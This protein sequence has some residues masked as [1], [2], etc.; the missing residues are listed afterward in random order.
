MSVNR[1][2]RSKSIA[3]TSTVVAAAALAVTS[4]IA[5]GGCESS[6][7]TPTNPV[8]GG[9]SGG[10]PGAKCSPDE[11][12]APMDGVSCAAMPDDYT[13]RE[14]GSSTDTWP[15]CISDKND[16]VP[17]DMNISSLARVAAFEQIREL[18]DIGGTGVPTPQD[19]LDA[20][21]IY[22]QEQGIESRVSRRE[23]EHYPPAPAACRDMPPAEQQMY[24]DRCVGPVKI[25]PILNAAFEGGIAGESPVENAARIEGALLWFFYVSIY[26][27]AT[28]AA[29]NAVDV[30]SM[31][32]KYTGGEPRE[33]GI[34]LSGYIKPRSQEAH[35]RIWDGLLAVR[36]WRDLDN[37]TGAAMDLALRDRARA[38]LDRALLR[39]M[40]LIL[41]Q[42]L[43]RSECSAAWESVKILGGVLDREATARDPANAAILR[44]E[45]QKPTSMDV[46]VAAATGALDALFPCP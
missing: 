44:A 11:G 18:L 40:A 33:G 42:R 32:A 37:P 3:R 26:K 15:A 6:D 7:P 14:S 16:Y 17:F 19:F 34:G 41:R 4:M 13:P 27:E 8:G 35:D 28:T 30:D 45:V 5:A 38:Q 21:V 1:S 9:G 10:S 2:L 39:G 25:R 12:T 23:D 36:C 31:W 46:D 43:E 24:P 20:R 29:Q 22:A